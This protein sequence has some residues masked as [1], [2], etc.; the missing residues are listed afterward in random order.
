LLMIPNDSPPGARVF[1]HRG[2]IVSTRPLAIVTG[3][4]SGIGYELAMLCAKKEIAGGRKQETGDRKQETKGRNW[5]EP[6][7]CLLSPVSCL[8][9]PVS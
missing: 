1:S 3:A 9:S 5:H 4:S 6:V 2:T 7:S 8:L